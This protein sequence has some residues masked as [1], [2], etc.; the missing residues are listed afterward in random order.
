[1]ARL[2][3]I[4]L[5]LSAGCS[6]ALGGPDAQRP[7]GRPPQCDTGKGLVV[8]DALFATGLGI[9]A[10]SLAGSSNSSEK[11]VALVPLIVGGLYA[12]AALRGNNVVNECRKAQDEFVADSE[13]PPQMP[14]PRVVAKEARAPEVAPAAAPAPKPEPK[15]E[16]RPEPRPEPKP[17]PGPWSEFWKELP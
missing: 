5:A 17:E 10:L 12:G 15:P 7:K 6:F 16:P 13:P 11:D 8:V 4:V 14:P 3:S 1:M 9:A 2:L